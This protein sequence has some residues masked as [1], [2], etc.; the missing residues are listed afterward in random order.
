MTMFWSLAAVMILIALLFILPALFRTGKAGA[1]GI[2]HDTLNVGV[3]RSQLAE[4]EADLQ[5]GRLS[6]DQYA[7][8]RSDLEQEL[9]NDLDG[10]DSGS[11]KTR[12]GQWAAII[13]VVGIPLLAAGLY[14]MLGS[15][16][17]IP[18]LAQMQANPPPAATADKG[19]MS[20]E[21][22][23]EKLAQR[24]RSQPDDMKGWVML[25]RSYVVL[26]RYDAAV[27]AY[28]NI[29]R[30]GGNS[31]ELLADYADALAMAAGG[32]F[33]PETG[34]VLTRALAAEPDNI[35]ALW[36]A[37]H[38]KNQ[39]GDYAAAIEY[40]QQAAAQLPADGEDVAVINQQ[41][42]GAR[43]KL[44]L[45]PLASAQPAATAA[46]APVE[47]SAPAAAT[48]IQ[49]SVSLDPQF[50]AQ[51]KPDDTVFIF[52]RAAQGPRMPLAIVRKQVRDLPLSVSLDDSLA[53]S[54]AMVLSKFGEVSVGARISSS[55]NAMPQSGDLQGS[56][57]PV[58]VG[59]DSQVE[60][61][62][63]SRVP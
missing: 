57:S 46:A 16:Q 21:E 51:V 18:L 38:W 2:D 48:A 1:S 37:G 35:K 44:G 15:Q 63:D 56:K 28:R 29:L 10:S 31:A 11:G 53:M 52:A 40:W 23:V 9:L 42:A 22:M 61:T 5:T 36:L 14:N 43:E 27:D 8:A 62:I 12:S 59:K 33:T 50:A 41:I 26:K 4:L 19:Q 49:V 24:M 55:G 25:A 54:P 7:A 13:L 45:P 39:E 6:E 47:T 17:I 3:I 30:L 32:R 34:E 20:V 58:V 60:I